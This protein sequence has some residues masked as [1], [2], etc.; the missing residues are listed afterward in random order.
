[1]ATLH[2][3][4]QSFRLR[5]LPLAL[6]GIGMGSIIAFYHASFRWEVFVLTFLT[7][8]LL[9]VLSNLANDYGDSMNGA[10]H[11]GRKGPS[12]AVQSGAISAKAMKRAVIICAI[13]SLVSGISLLIVSL[14]FS[15][16][17]LAF[18][19]IGIAAIVAAIKYTMGKNPYG[20]AGF[21]DLFVLLFFG[22]VSVMGAYFLHQKQLDY[23]LLLPSLSTGLF[24]VAVLNVN[25][26]R[27]IDSDTKAGKRSIPVML[28][29]KR[30]KIYHGILLGVGLISMV[31]YT[32]FFVAGTPYKWLFVMTFPLFYRHYN[33]V[34]KGTQVADFDPL[35][36]QMA[37]LSLQ[38]VLL[39]GIGLCFH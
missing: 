35:L 37:L 9:Q 34:Y 23:A 22:F 20:Y 14:Q 24:A 4:I 11:D 7:T 12:R 33:A 19:I 1:M 39:Y 15:L 16:M 36:K 29:Q 8:V 5:T 26:I 18:F 21:G 13:L 27:D 2:T 3:W 30:A 28:G 32:H 25:N 31:V 6:S 10:D 38:F 17:F